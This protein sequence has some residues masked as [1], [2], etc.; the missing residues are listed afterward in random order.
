MICYECPCACAKS[1]AAA[2][3]DA[4][5][6]TAV[7]GTHYLQITYKR[8]DSIRL[9]KKRISV[10]IIVVVVVLIVIIA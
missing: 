10:D 5:V 1:S 7:T 6:T 4:A 8:N 9:L 3:G 2:G